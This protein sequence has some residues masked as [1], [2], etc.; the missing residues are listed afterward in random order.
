MYLR[1]SSMLP[2]TSSSCRVSSAYGKPGVPSTIHSPYSGFHASPTRPLCSHVTGR[3]AHMRGVGHR[4]EQQDPAHRARTYVS[5]SMAWRRSNTSVPAT[6]RVASPVSSSNLTMWYSICRHQCHD[7]VPSVHK[8]RHARVA[9]VCVQRTSSP[10]RNTSPR[11]AWTR[12]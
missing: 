4:N 6:K 12:R 10:H 7:N 1:R 2:S 8:V 3:W 11:R 9:H 5:S